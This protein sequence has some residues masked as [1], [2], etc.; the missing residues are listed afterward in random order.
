MNKRKELLALAKKRQA[1]RWDGYKGIGDY[2]GGVYECDF[3]SPYT[4]TAGDV[5]ADIMVMLQDWW[6]DDG[7]SGPIDEDSVTLGY[8]RTNR[9]NINLIRLLRETFGLTLPDV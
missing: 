2:H 9:T 6:S 1:T 4:K 7:M 3:V 8:G 5:D